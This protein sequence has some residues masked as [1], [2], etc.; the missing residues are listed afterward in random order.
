MNSNEYI[1]PDKNQLIAMLRSAIATHSRGDLSTVDNEQI[2]LVAEGRLHE[3]E[4]AQRD[5]LLRQIAGTPDAALLLKRLHD[6]DLS[7]T[8]LRGAAREPHIFRIA[9]GMLAIAASLMIGLLV[10]RLIVPTPVPMHNGLVPFT[11]PAQPD[12]WHQLDE[13]RRQQ[14]IKWCTYRDY[15]LVF[16]TVSCLV[17]SVGVVWIA[18][19][20]R[21]QRKGI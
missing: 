6:L 16:S 2:T 13:Q 9:T 20:R 8:A 10:T 21:K 12:Y 17:L 11:A 14:K 19:R 3:L 7:G 4:P 15:A 18:L 1:T 5:R